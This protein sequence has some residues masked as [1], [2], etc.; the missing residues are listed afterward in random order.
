MSLLRVFIGEN[1]GTLV[2]EHAMCETCSEAL[3][4]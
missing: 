1:I 3:H 2:Q 4:G